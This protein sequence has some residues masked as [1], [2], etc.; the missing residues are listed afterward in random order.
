MEPDPGSAPTETLVSVITPTRG[1][2]RTFLPDA[3]AS[4]AAQRTPDWL[5][6]EHVIADDGSEPADVRALQKL[7]DAH[8]HIRIVLRHHSGGVSAARNDA[9][10]ASSGSIV[11]DLDDDDILPSTSIADRVTHLIGSGSTWACGNMLKVDEELRYLIGSDET[12]KWEPMPDGQETLQKLV[13]GTFLAWSGTR[14]YHR[15]TIEQAGPWD[16]TFEVAEDLEHWMRLTALC[17]PPAWCDRWLVIWRYKERS[18][19]ID[20]GRDGRMKAHV[21]RARERWSGWLPG[22]PVPAGVPSW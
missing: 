6:I 21:A 17:G 12:P 18:L 14:T 20:S 5:R 19:G 8:D 4:V 10:L 11:V 2:A 3:I 7:A 22:D 1:R 13:E 16:A 15:S 9:F